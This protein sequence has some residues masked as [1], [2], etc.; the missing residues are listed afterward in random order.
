MKTTITSKELINNISLLLD[1]FNFHYTSNRNQFTVYG[2]ENENIYYIFRSHISK[3]MQNFLLNVDP[4]FNIAIIDIPP[5][6][7]DE[8]IL[9]E[10]YILF[11]KVFYARNKNKK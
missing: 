10:F 4:A 3:F 11:E 5:L 1:E 9:S 2:N 6:D 8:S 7:F